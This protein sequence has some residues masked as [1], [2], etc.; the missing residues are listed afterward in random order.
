M[1]KHQPGALEME[2][3]SL[4]TLK[5]ARTLPTPTERTNPA[6]TSA[7]TAVFAGR[8]HKDVFISKPRN[9]STKFAYYIKKDMI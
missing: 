9:I 6:T 1:A 3:E 5:Y 7:T 4:E 2:K 8:A